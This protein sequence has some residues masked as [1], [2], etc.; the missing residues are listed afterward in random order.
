MA[1]ISKYCVKM[2]NVL[3]IDIFTQPEIN[4]LH[5]GDILTSLYNCRIFAT[6]TEIYN[7]V[8]TV[9]APPAGYPKGYTVIRLNVS[10]SKLHV[11]GL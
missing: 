8:S 7:P 1:S 10:Q 2:E 6:V 4:F 3:L 9:R 5:K 11:G